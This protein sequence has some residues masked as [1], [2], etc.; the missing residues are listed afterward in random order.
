MDSDI[1]SAE[2]YYDGVFGGRASIEGQGNDSQWF[3]GLLANRPISQSPIKKDGLDGMGTRQ[4]SRKD[5]TKTTGEIGRA[6][7]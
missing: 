3:G 7:V 2:S 6:H 1:L 4:P 5:S